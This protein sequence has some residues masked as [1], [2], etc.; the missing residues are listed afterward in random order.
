MAGRY[1]DERRRLKTGDVAL[2]S[3][4]GRIS[5]IIMRATGSRFSHVA[6]VVVLKEL[7][8]VALWESTTLS[9]VRDLSSGEL[10]QGVQLVPLS[11]RLEHYSGAVYVR[12]LSK[13]LSEDQLRRLSDF[14][15][16]V[17]GRPYEKS[18]LELASTLWNEF[19]GQED[20][21]S[22]FCSELVAETFQ[23]IGLLGD[24]SA[25]G[26]ASNKYQPRDFSMDEEIALLADYELGSEIR[27]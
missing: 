6:M 17:A 10:R 21:S 4:K 25:G 9:N 18:V 15:R 13:T 5:E 1:E 23:Q 11:D 22:L 8:L 3:G 24:V 26:K 7:D 20:L 27:L 19:G 16:T 12:K 2:F 14:R